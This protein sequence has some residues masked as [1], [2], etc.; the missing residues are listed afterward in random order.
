[1]PHSYR[2]KYVLIAVVVLLSGCIGV[3]NV[4]KA[5]TITER[6]DKP[7]K[8]RQVIQGSNTPSK[9]PQ[10]TDVAAIMGKPYSIEKSDDK[11]KW[12]YKDGVAWRG[13]VVWLIAPLPLIA[14]VGKN[15]VV[16]EFKD[17]DLVSR[18]YVNEELHYTGICFLQWCSW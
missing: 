6:C 13:I 3:T 10:K 7:D 18:T 15:D 8:C 2:I 16:Y 17:D 11:E 4:T 12:S 5:P 9:N 14:P 1:M